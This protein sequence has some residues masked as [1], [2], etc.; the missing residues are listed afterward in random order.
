METTKQIIREW[1]ELYKD[2]GATH[3]IIVCDDFS[4][5]DYP[6]PVMPGDDVREVEEDH[7]GN[8]QHVM[9]IYNFSMDIEEQLNKEGRAYNR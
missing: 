3:L 7:N 8:M 5:E 9:E 4:Y 2:S 6:V 1:L